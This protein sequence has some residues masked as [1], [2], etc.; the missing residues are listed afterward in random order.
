MAKPA[1]NHAGRTSQTG[2][3]LGKLQLLGEPTTDTGQSMSA[4]EP[5]PPAP[6]PASTVILVRNSSRGTEVLLLRRPDR[7][8]A[9]G[10][11]V[12]PGGAVDDDD[13]RLNPGSA[14][15]TA[16]WATAMHLSDRAAAW[17]YVVAGV[18]ETWEETGVPLWS[19][20]AR[21]EVL[22]RARKRCYEAGE[23][24]ST[25]VSTLR[26]EPGRMSYLSRWITPE[27][28]PRRYDTRFFVAR[29][30]ERCR[31]APAEGEVEEAIWIS[32]REALERSAAGKL[33]L[34]LPTRHSLDALVPFATAEL[35]LVGLRRDVAPAYLPRMRTTP[36]GVII[37]V[38]PLD[39]ADGP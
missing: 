32:P 9:A 5:T 15:E 19:S 1:R 27:T 12:F 24:F 30:E 16:T 22:D 25:I 2:A 11:W 17:A 39:R 8:F 26:L 14:E 18:R 3:G 37:D 31:I 38:H 33:H 36:K 6:R 4:A 35:M 29:V 28:E 34:M 20:D 21:P 13:Y 7:G 10:A 23:P